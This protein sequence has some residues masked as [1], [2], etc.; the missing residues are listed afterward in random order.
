LEANGA[1]VLRAILVPAGEPAP[2]GALPGVV[3]EP[4][5]DLAA[6]LATVNFYR[7]LAFRLITEA[8][9]W[10]RCHP[11]RVTITTLCSLVV[12]ISRNWRRPITR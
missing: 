9:H 1:G 4:D 6:L 3:A 11:S 2:A 8:F 5:D 12:T 7:T 10:S